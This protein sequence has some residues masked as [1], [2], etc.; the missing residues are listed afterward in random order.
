METLEDLRPISNLPISDKIQ[1]P[2]ISDMIIIDMKNKL[3][4]TQFG[5]QK[6]TSIPHY[7]IKIMHRIV[8]SVDRNAKGEI[9]AILAL[10]I[11]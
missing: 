5:N 9:N 11:D 2:V 6:N 8:S 1:E 7:L 3:D 10:F 4:P